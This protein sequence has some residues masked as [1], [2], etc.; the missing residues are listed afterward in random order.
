MLVSVMQ[1]TNSG[2]VNRGHSCE[3][4]GGGNDFLL[5]TVGYINGQFINFC[6]CM[7]CSTREHAERERER[8]RDNYLSY[9]LSA[10]FCWNYARACSVIA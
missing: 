7:T 2:L 6:T 3:C 5:M 10:K 8:Q 1:T 4:G 9:K